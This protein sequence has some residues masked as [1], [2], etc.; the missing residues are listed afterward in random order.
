VAAPVVSNGRESPLVGGGSE[1]Y[2]FHHAEDLLDHHRLSTSSLVED[3]SASLEAPFHATPAEKKPRHHSWRKAWSL[4]GLIHRRATGRR[5]DVADRAFSETRVR[6]CN[7]RMHRCSS[8]ASARSSFS[9]NSGGL[10]SS[11]R[12]CYVDAHGHVKR[13]RGEDRGARYS[14]GHA[15][16]GMLRFYLTPMR[17]ASCRRTPG[18]Q[19]RP[20]SFARTMLRL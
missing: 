2:H 6:G 7:G 11:R 12:S 14:P 4:W 17:S 9:S 16:N 19:L 10:G 1:F 18:R 20:Q 5:T 3:F 8:N 15:D 13:R